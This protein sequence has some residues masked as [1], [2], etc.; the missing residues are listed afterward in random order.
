MYPNYDWWRVADNP[1]ETRLRLTTEWSGPGPA[2]DLEAT[3]RLGYEHV[4]RFNYTDS[5]RSNFFVQLMAGYR[6]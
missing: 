6:W 5:N 3:V 1:D 2:E 4:T